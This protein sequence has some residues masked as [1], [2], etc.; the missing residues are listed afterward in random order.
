MVDILAEA[1][2]LRREQDLKRIELPE[3][4]IRITDKLLGRGGFG[5]VYIADFNGRHVAAKVWRLS[6]TRRD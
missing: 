2:R 1:R 4:Q 6:Y 5:A 3:G